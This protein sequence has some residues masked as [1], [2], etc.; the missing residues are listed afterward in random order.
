MPEPKADVN[1]RD[2][3]QELLE[4]FASTFLLLLR[5]AFE[6]IET[7]EHLLRDSQSEL[8]PA[9]WDVLAIIAVYGPARPADILRLDVLTRKQQTLSS[10]I[11]RLEARELIV[12][13]EDG[14]DSR[15]V[16]LTITAKGER[17]V[18]LLFP[19]IASKLIEPFNANFTDQ[20]LEVL[21]GLLTR[22]RI[23]EVSP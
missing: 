9:E 19:V 13:S 6:S 11:K 2:L 18:G 3:S 17:L 22:L 1:P 4:T 15:S 5:T 7:L 20:E 23:P 16:N 10:I 12:R 14:T 21:G 8:K